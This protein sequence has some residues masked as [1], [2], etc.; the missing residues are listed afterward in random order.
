MS[1][2]PENYFL[3][4][5]CPSSRQ[6]LATPLALNT[7]LIIPVLHRYP[8][9]FY[10]VDWKLNGTDGIDCNKKDVSADGESAS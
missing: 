5:S 9:S 3:L 1:R 7:K 4:V 2:S 6:I 10:A 8:S